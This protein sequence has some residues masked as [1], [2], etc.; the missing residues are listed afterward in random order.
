LRS[1]TIRR[2]LSPRRLTAPGLLP[3]RRHLASL[4]VLLTFVAAGVGQAADSWIFRPS[5]YTHDP[6]GGRRVSQYAPKQPAY[7]RTDP[8]YMQSGYRHSRST[9]RGI[10]GSVDRRH[11]VETWGAGEMIRPYG[12]WQRPFRAGATPYGPWGNPGGPWTMPFDSWSNPYGLG[13]LQHPPWP[14]L[15]YPMAAPYAEPYPGGN[16]ALSPQLPRGGPY[17]AS[18]RVAPPHQSG[19]H[20]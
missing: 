4:V 2:I 8:T 17:R 12:E 11:V 5:H 9:L 18:P 7:V 13:N 1:S 10:G 3:M 20:P 19:G 14:H 16:P 15:E 6:E